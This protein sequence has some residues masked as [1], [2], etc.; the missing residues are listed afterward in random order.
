MK[1]VL[2]LSLLFVSAQA[3][4]NQFTTAYQTGISVLKNYPEWVVGSF[5]LITN[6]KRGAWPNITGGLL[7]ASVYGVHRAMGGSVNVPYIIAAYA[8]GYAAAK[9]VSRPVYDLIDRFQ[10]GKRA[11]LK[12]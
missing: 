11:F 7:S 9:A 1:K 4:A 12:K 5:G 8:I 10:R 2:I 6:L 3:Q